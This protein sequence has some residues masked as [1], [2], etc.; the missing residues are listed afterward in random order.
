VQKTHKK[1]FQ[2]TKS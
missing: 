1:T 2:K